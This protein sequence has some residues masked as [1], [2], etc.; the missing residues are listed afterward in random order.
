MAVMSAPRAPRVTDQEARLITGG[1]SCPY[2]NILMTAKAACTTIQQDFCSNQ[3]TDCGM[4]ACPYNC[5]PVALYW[6]SKDG[7]MKGDIVVDPLRRDGT[8]L[9]ESQSPCIFVDPNCVCDITQA[10]LKGE[11]APN[12]GL[13]VACEK[14]Q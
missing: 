10:Q 8:C 5:S 14:Q 12:P 11:C 7:T 2:D 6:R 4:K 13:F 3:T 1:D 9:K